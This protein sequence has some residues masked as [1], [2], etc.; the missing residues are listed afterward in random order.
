MF[1]MLVWSKIL[2]ASSCRL[3]KLRSGLEFVHIPR[4]L[5]VQHEAAGVRPWV[6]VWCFHMVFFIYFFGVTS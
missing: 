2:F 3:N 1:F 6:H 4:Y 5:L